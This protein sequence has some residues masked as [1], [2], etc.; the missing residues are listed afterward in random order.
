MK[1]LWSTLTFLLAVFSLHAQTQ[2]KPGIGVNFLGISG[3]SVDDAKGQVGWQVGGSIAFG[4][5]FYFEPGVFYQTESAEFS[6]ANDPQLSD[7]KLNGFRIPVAVGFDLLGNADSTV[8]LRVFGG[9]SGFFLA[10][11]SDGLDK[12]DYSSPQWGVFAGAGVDL[13][14]IYLDLSYQWSVTDI[15]KDIS[16]IDL[17]KTKGIFLTAGL[18]F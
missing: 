13:T 9:G 17:G 8:G 16:N 1:K 10:S 5:K 15:Q 18:R 11:V 6:S 2:V 3:S 14:I 12:D 4:E 7:L